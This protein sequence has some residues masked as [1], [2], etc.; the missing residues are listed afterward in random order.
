MTDGQAWLVAR[1]LKRH[2]A[3]ATK[4]DDSQTSLYFAYGSNL[5]PEQMKHRCPAGRLVG[6]AALHGYRLAFRGEGSHWGVGGTATILADPK[7]WVPGTLYRL[8]PEDVALLNGYE[9]YP[10]TYGHLAIQVAESGGRAQAAFTY[11]RMDTRLRR[12]PSMKYFH[13]IWRSYKRHGLDEA[14]LMAAVEESLNGH[15]PARPGDA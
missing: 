4:M 12:P 3:I 9:G 14:R 8:S 13:Q 10:S 11:E 7:G 6:T 15:G 5:D 1:V 2:N